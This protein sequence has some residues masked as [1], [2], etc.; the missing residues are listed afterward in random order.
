MWKYMKIVFRLNVECRVFQRLRR[1]IH[2][3]RLTDSLT[4]WLI[5]G[6]YKGIKRICSIHMHIHKPPDRAMLNPMLHNIIELNWIE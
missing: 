5:F 1:T 2:F 6:D 3:P 4:E